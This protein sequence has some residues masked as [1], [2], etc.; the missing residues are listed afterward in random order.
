MEPVGCADRFR[1]VELMPQGMTRLNQTSG[2]TDCRCTSTCRASPAFP[3]CKDVC[4]QRSRG[5]CDPCRLRARRRASGGGR[6]PAAVSGHHQHR[7][8]SGICPHHRGLEADECAAASI[9]DSAQ[10]QAAV[11]IARLCRSTAP[12]GGSRRGCGCSGDQASPTY[13]TGHQND[14]GAWRQPPVFSR[15]GHRVFPTTEDI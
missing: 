15:N 2:A 4:C 11:A 6:A 7:A 9:R 3:C 13:R 10:H 12:H 14:R 1:N 5:C 8:G